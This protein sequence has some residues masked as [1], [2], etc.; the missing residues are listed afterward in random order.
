MS[1]TLYLAKFEKARKENKEKKE[2]Y[3]QVIISIKTAIYD[4][5]DNIVC[6]LNGNESFLQIGCFVKKTT[7]KF[8]KDC[9]LDISN[10]TS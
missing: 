5:K 1:E 8:I 6:G 3:S 10:H 2:T 4:I 9:F 7:D